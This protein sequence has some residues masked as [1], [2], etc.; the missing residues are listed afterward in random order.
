MTSILT[1]T[2]SQKKT[3]GVHIILTL[4]DCPASLLSYVNDSVA[5]GEHV[6]LESDLHKVSMV[7]HQFEPIGATA[8]FLLTESHIS[9]HTW[10]E[11]GIVACDI[12]CC[13]DRQSLLD[14]LTKAKLA[15]TLLE[16]KFEAKRSTQQILYR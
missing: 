8:L 13:T 15:S 1:D 3:I 11:K 6:L 5:I 16:Q 10:P 12:F 2:E 14:A 4:Y 7:S 9:I